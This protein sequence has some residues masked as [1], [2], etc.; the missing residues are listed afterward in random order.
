[1]FQKEHRWFANSE[2]A[3]TEQTIIETGA[4]ITAWAVGEGEVQVRSL[5]ELVWP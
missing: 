3:L 1:M 2:G 4:G 5:P